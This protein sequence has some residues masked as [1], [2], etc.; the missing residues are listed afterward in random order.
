MLETA[1]TTELHAHYTQAHVARAEM[2]RNIAGKI[3]GLLNREGP[4]L[5]PRPS[6]AVAC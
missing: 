2:F 1:T 4:Q 5:A 6:K 3:F